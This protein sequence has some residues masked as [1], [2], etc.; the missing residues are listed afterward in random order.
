MPDHEDGGTPNWVVDNLTGDVVGVR[1]KDKT[2]RPLLRANE[3]VPFGT[4]INDGAVAALSPVLTAAINA[5]VAAAF[6]LGAAGTLVEVT[7]Y[8]QKTATGLVFS[9]PCEYGGFEVVSVT[10]SPTIKVYDG[11]DTSGTVLLDTTTLTVDP[12]RP[13]ERKLKL[14]LST[15]LYIVITGTATVNMLVG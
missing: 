9:G 15:G 10:A 1:L 6:P 3:V 5:A 13:F 11:V 12:T 2:I 14:S 8:V 7:P 4:N